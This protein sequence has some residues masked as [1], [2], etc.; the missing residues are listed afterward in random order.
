MDGGVACFVVSTGEIALRAHPVS[1]RRVVPG[2]QTIPGS[3]HSSVL[4]T[5][6]GTKKYGSRKQS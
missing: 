4:H 2:G 6:D 3:H 1:I 5:F